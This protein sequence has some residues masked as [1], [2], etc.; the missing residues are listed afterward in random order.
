VA[1]LVYRTRQHA[2]NVFLWPEEGGLDSTPVHEA[3]T[4]INALHWTKDGMAV[5]VVS[6]AGREELER[7]AALLREPAS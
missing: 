1:A 2:I 3:R 6:D 4:G 5:W 7:L